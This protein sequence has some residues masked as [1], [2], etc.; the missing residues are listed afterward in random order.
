MLIFVVE[1]EGHI[2]TVIEA[3]VR[4]QPIA[5]I[6]SPKETMLSQ[7]VNGSCDTLPSRERF[8]NNKIQ[9]IYQGCSLI[10]LGE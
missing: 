1:I 5:N 3:L 7:I 4:L 8:E 2:D 6:N 10:G 9:I